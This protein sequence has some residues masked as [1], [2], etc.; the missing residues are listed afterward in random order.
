M[1][2]VSSE[3]GGR[4]ERLL[5]LRYSFYNEV[6]KH[7]VEPVV[8]L[9]PIS[10]EYVGLGDLHLVVVARGPIGRCDTRIALGS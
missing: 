4:G 7:L 8:E 6:E 2:S 9:V 5:G 3:V 10:I 1:L